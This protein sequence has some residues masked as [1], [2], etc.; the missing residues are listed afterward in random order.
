MIITRNNYE[1][2]F[3]LYMDNELGNEDRRQVELFVKENPDLQQEL[4]LL[5]QTKMDPDDSFAF[6]NKEQ[7]HKTPDG[8][9]IDTTN[10]EEWILSYI[11]NELPVQQKIGVDKF[12]ANHQTAKTELELLQKIKLQA[13]TSIVFA[14]K[15]ILYRSEEK[16]RVIGIHW[17]RIAAA[18]ALLLAV[19]TTA[20]FIFTNKKDTQG[21]IALIPVKENIIKKAPVTGPSKSEVLITP[22]AA[23]KT[24]DKT[25]NEAPAN[26]DQ[27][28]KEKKLQPKQKIAPYIPVE[29]TKEEVAVGNKEKK[30]MNGL[31]QPTHNPYVN[32]LAEQE[33]PIASRLTGKESLTFPNEKKQLPSVTPN[34]TQPLDH[35]ET[36]SLTESTDPVDEERPGK[37]NKLRGFFRKITR[38]FEKTTNIKATDDE[39]RLLLGGLAIKL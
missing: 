6:T 7:L 19:S 21:D 17:K 26:N 32:K 24:N 13:D 14:N 3:I 9:S 30:N 1:E 10:Y 31:P 29:S 28:V 38:T 15:E 8:I 12:I 34:T 11:D 20:L 27:L 2:Y 25:E 39:D 37:K 36:A 5:M 16:V 35:V 22:Q 18:A 4:N 23:G 33:N